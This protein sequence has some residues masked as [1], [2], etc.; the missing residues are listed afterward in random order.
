MPSARYEQSPRRGISVSRAGGGAPAPVEKVRHMATTATFRIWR[1]DGD[2]GTLQD[3]TTAISEGMVVLD[4]VHQ[5]QAEQAHDLGGALEL[6]GGQVRIVLGRGQR[7]PA[8]DVHDPPESDRPLEADH[9]R[10]DAELP[11]DPRPGHRR[12]VE[13]P[14]QEDNQA[15]QAPAARCARRY[16]AHG[17][18]RRRT[19]AGVPEVHRVLPVPGRLPRVARASALQRVRR[20]APARLR[21]RAGDAPARHREAGGR[22]E[23]RA[24][25]R[26][27]ATSPSA[28]PRSVPRGLPSPTTPS[29]RSRSAS[30]I[31]S[32]T[33]SPSC[34]GCC[35]ASCCPSSEAGPTPRD[36]CRPDSRQ[37][38][39][40]EASHGIRAE[41]AVAGRGAPRAGKGRPLP[42]AQRAGR[43]RQHLPRRARRRRR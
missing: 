26:A 16:L 19:G 11:A 8:P 9:A 38:R 15:L 28:A 21:G 29:F 17:A 25:R 20:A 13:L 10:A 41:D 24:R 23:A 43:G 22:P 33:R 31:S 39:A 7:Q 34:S 2:G 12:V 32:T 36:C 6:Q 27:T 37:G 4:A 35:A 30:S 3:Y 14:R 5:I 1:G 18:G 42:P 40:L